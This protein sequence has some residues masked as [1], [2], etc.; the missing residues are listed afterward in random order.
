MKTRTLAR[1]GIL[2][3]LLCAFSCKKQRIERK[4]TGDF[5]FT[6][7]AVTW[8]LSSGNHDYTYTHDGR[9]EID[10]EIYNHYSGLSEKS[11][12]LKI[13]FLNNGGY[14]NTGVDTHGNFSFGGVSGG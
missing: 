7:H 14:G 13:Y 3:L 11:T 1:I 6:V 4:Y 10:K 2:L 8:D 12:Y 9:I 5:T